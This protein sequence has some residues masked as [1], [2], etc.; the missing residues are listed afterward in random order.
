M[1]ALN[2]GRKGGWNMSAVS[3]LV[4]AEHFR[5]VAGHAT[6]EDDFLLQLKADAKAADLPEIWIA[7]EQASFVQVLLKLCKAKDVVEVGTLAGYSAIRM[8]RS[9]PV[10]G[11]VRTIEVSG[12]HADFAEKWIAKSD[13]ADR[14][15]VYRGSGKDILPKFKSSSADAVFLDAD[16]RSYPVYLKECLRIVRSGGLIMA[17]NAFGY[18]RLLDH[19]ADDPQVLAIREFNDLMARE[20]SLNG[21]I[22]PLGDGLWVAVKE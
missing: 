6:Q 4:T 14:I 16:S 21:V 22:V 18:G 2:V 17:D 11:R 7:A 20:P 13:V 8:A 19:D 10:G 12:K 3:T 9:L 15:T 1:N 5:Y